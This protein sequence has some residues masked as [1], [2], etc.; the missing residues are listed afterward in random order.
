MERSSETARGLGAEGNVV[1]LAQ[2]GEKAAGEES[3]GSGVA[4]DA[5]LES[6]KGSI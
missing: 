2:A 1:A 4:S 6:L 5:E 3:F